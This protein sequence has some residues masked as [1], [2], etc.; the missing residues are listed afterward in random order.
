[1]LPYCDI[2]PGQSRPDKQGKRMREGNIGQREGQREDKKY[3]QK[4]VDRHTGY[5]KD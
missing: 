3:K 1:M 2:S 4:E 5:G